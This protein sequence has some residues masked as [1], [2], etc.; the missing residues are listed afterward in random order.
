MREYKFRGKDIYTGKWV[1]GSLVILKGAYFIFPEW[2]YTYFD[3]Y[4]NITKNKEEASI[5]GI[6]DW[7]EVD[8][9][10][11]GQFTGKED[12]NNKEIYDGDILLI[13]EEDHALP[14]V[15]IFKE[16]CFGFN[17][18]WLNGNLKDT[19][20]IPLKEYCNTIFINFVEI[21]GNIYDN[22]ELMNIK[23]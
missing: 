12:K 19:T 16:G 4:D 15:V 5:L 6:Y 20:F 7:S 3:K 13:G 2:G 9:K 22:P 11:V 10:T 1:Y 17:A 14:Q 21:I 23:K 18:S 8:P